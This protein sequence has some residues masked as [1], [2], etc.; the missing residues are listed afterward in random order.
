MDN[1]YAIPPTTGEQ[2]CNVTNCAAS[3]ARA[4]DIASSCTIRSA[5]CNVSSNVEG[6]RMPLSREG[7]GGYVLVLVAASRTRDGVGNKQSVSAGS[8]GEDERD[9]LGSASAKSAV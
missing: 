5:G 6:E 3:P 8:A 4:S 9:S 2:G 1:E 7:T